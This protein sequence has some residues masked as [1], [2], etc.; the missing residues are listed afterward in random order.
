LAKFG[1]G[2]LNRVWPNIWLGPTRLNLA[3]ANSIE[4]WLELSKAKF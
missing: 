1:W 3:G 2:R 4:I